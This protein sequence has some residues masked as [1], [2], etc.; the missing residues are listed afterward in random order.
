MET[1][2]CK[3]CGYQG[4]QLCDIKKHYNKKHICNPIFC[5]LSYE[6]LLNK[7]DRGEHCHPIHRELP[8]PPNIM[9][10]RTPP[11]SYKVGE[12]Y[13]DE[14]GKEY[15][16][17][18]LHLMHDTYS[19]REFLEEVSKGL[20]VLRVKEDFYDKNIDV[21]LIVTN[22]NSLLLLE[23]NVVITNT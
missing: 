18:G 7:I 20:K 1:F 3:R 19:H 21:D 6:E 2:R 14:D 10:V 13:K 9:Y 11:N 16:I 17:I 12:N 15:K 4:K 5:D 22:E 8:H 23:P